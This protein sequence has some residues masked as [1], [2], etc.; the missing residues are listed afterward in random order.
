M[1][2]LEYGYGLLFLSYYLRKIKIFGRQKLKF[3][4]SKVLQVKNFLLPEVEK[5][6]QRQLNNCLASSFGSEADVIG[7]NV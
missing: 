6:K 1:R 7:V 3:I 5:L 4:Y 2:S